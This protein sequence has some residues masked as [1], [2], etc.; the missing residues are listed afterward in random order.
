MSQSTQTPA[1]GRRIGSDRVVAIGALVTM[2]LLFVMGAL[3][4]REEAAVAAPATATASAS[5]EGP[6]RA[7]V[8][9]RV[10]DP[11]LVVND[12]GSATVSAALMNPNDDEVALVDVRVEIDGR[13]VP[14]S[15]TIMWLPLQPG[16]SSQVGAASDAGGFM[17]PSGV[18]AGAEARLTFRF[19]SGPCVH[20]VAPAVARS[21][22]H[23]LIYPTSGR[24]LSADEPAVP[25]VGAACP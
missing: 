10:D 12:D 25:P 9:V 14:V 24:L 19:D 4:P 21:G 5:P 20:V 2:V 23:S 22:E 15:S 7:V 18:L 17:V 16:T 11:L 13:P 6:P 8:P 1:S 3:G